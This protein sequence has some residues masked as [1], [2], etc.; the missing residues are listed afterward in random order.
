MSSSFAVCLFFVTDYARL[1]E[2]SDYLAS[3][4]NMVRY[5]FS[6]YYCRP[7][8]S[9]LQYSSNSPSVI[10]CLPSDINVSQRFF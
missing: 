7:L 4:D 10:D 6:V 3:E 9:L 1:S 5:I 2:T 8:I